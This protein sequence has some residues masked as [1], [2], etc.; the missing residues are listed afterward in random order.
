M[1]IPFLNRCGSLSPLSLSLSL[2]DRL[3]ENSFLFIS[4][5][6]F[7]LGCVTRFLG[8]EVEPGSHRCAPIGSHARP[9]GFHRGTVLDC[10]L[11]IEFR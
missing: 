7:L 2:L 8:R 10:H 1:P 6:E 11:P 5:T 4:V 9:M 3:M